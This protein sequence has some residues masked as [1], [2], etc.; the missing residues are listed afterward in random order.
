MFSPRIYWRLFETLNTNGWPI[1][2]PLLAAGG[3][4]MAWSLRSG[5]ASSSRAP[6]W[7]LVGCALGWLWVAWAYHWQLFKP[8]QPAAGIFTAVFVAQAALLMGAAA[9][10]RFGGMT[11][12]KRRLLGQSLLGLGLLGFPMLILATER[13][14]RGA[15]LLGLAPD[16]TAVFTLGLLCL[17]RPQGLWRLS[18]IPPVLWCAMSAAT[19]ATMGAWQAWVLLGV[20]AALTAT[21]LAYR[22]GRRSVPG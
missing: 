12:G 22:A 17:L 10:G 21:G 11:S 7:L 19:L 15:E 6:R 20:L 2:L 4:A 14:W 3:A 5:Q 16:P 1:Q 9:W 18:W 8:I 13:P